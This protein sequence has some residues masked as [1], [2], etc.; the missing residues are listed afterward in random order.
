MRH[1]WRGAG[2]GPEAEV[3]LTARLDGAQ[4]QNPRRG[5]LPRLRGG[6]RNPG[7]L[8]DRRCRRRTWRSCAGERGRS[9]AATSTRSRDDGP[10]YRVGLRCS[11]FGI[12]RDYRGHDGMRQLAGDTGTTP[13]P[14]PGP[15]SRSRRGRRPGG[16]R[17]VHV[18][19]R[20]SNRSL[21]DTPPWVVDTRCAR[22]D[23][24]ASA[25]FERGGGPRSRGAPRVGD[26]AGERG[27]CPPAHRGVR[28]WGRRAWS[29]SFRR[30]RGRG[31]LQP[32]GG[33]REVIWHGHAGLARAYVSFRG[34]FSTIAFEVR[35]L[36]DAR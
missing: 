6:A 26:V 10:R 25:C 27:D 35:R 17:R 36:V 23:A 13:F 28:R 9:T 19:A 18:R 2:Q 20:A 5:V 8:R 34:A 1:I 30:S 15:I 33:S 12:E 21:D 14:T 29:L 7:D 22:E 24:V 3:E 16:S 31:R 11:P 4:T 32:D